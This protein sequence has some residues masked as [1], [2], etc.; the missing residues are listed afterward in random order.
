MHRVP[1]VALSVCPE[2]GQTRRRQLLLERPVRDMLDRGR[3]ATERTAFVV[4]EA[5]FS[6][7]LLV[8]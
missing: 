1:L 8:D 7:H 3:Q 4:G 6:D 5:V 2:R